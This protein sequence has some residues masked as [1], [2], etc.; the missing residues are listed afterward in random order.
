MDQIVSKIEQKKIISICR[1]IYGEDILNLSKALY[2]GGVSFLEVTFDQADPDCEEKTAETIAMLIQRFP[3]MEFGAGT[4]LSV[5]QVLAAHQAGAKFII[6]PNTDTD[7]IRKTKELGMVSI[8]GAMTPSEI[9]TALNVGADLVK[10]FPC[11]Y[12][13]TQYV[14]EILSPLSHVKLVGTG[15]ISLENLKSFLDVGIYGFG[16]GSFLA[17]KKLIAE[18]NFAQIE[19]NAKAFMDIATQ[20]KG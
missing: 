17:S 10:L 9:M 12:L 19:A 1:K 2:R 7:V 4:V 15:G 8:P 6:S 3:E 14:K 20:P 11:S 16:I 13:G 5:K 18:G